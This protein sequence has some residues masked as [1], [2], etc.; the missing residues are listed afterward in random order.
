VDAGADGKA[1]QVQ[2]A[3]RFST[4][5]LVQ[6]LGKL[7]KDPDA[8]AALME[9]SRRS[10][11][12]H[13]RLAGEGV[14]GGPERERLIR[15]LRVNVLAAH[16]IALLAHTEEGPASRRVSTAK[17]RQRAMQLA[18]AAVVMAPDVPEAY[19]AMGDTLIEAGH[20]PEAAEAAYRQALLLAPASSSAH[21]KLAEALRREDR[22]PE[23]VA[24]LREALRLDASSA[25]AHTDLGLILEIQRDIDGAIAEHREAL[26]LAPDFIDAHNN[27]AITLA[28]QQRIPEAVAEFREIVRI[29]P[30]SVL[31]YYNLGIALAD[32]DKDDESA[33]AFRHVIRVNPNHYNTRFNIGEL[34]RLE[35]KLDEAVKQ[36]REYLRL[37][38]DSPQ[39]Q[40]N[41]RRAREFVATHENP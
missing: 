35:G 5:E 17:G 20:P 25:L 6:R 30:D 11:E 33:E 28:R 13:Q 37:A 40:R 34:F 9:L 12:L 14:R 10:E 19:W 21:I 8:V 1:I 3:A 38:P 41:I 31:G 23:A 16:V 7:R 26:R 22:L 27:L 24:E 4:V 29:D 36:F 18:E 15:T 2:V 32:M 39:N